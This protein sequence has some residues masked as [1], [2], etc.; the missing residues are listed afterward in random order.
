MLFLNKT[1]GL[2]WEISDEEHIQ[3]LLRNKNF[4]LVGEVKEKETKKVKKEEGA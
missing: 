1:T 2:K 4:E 3:S